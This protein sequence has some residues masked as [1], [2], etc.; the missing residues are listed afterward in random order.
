MQQ[1]QYN[2]MKAL[3]VYSG[4][5]DSTVL[6]HEYKEQIKLAVSFN[7][8]SKHAAQELEKAQ[9]NCEKLNIRHLV[10]DLP[11][12]NKLFRSS[13]LQGQ[14][15]I[16]EGGYNAENMSSTIVPF[17]NGIMLSI[18]AGIAESNG[19]DTLLIANHSGDHFIYPDCRESFIDA[20][21]DAIRQ[22]TEKEVAL[23][24]PYCDLSKRDIALRGHKFG[25][26]FSNT[27]SCYKGCETHCGKCATCM[28]RKE[29]LAG[30]DPTLY[31]NK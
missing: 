3:I 24:S 4:G 10:V 22:G 5:M 20:M 31:E 7:Y 16:P 1:H 25:I 27:Y 30:F 11:F 9:I 21:N 12:I 14:E 8:G 23:L 15:E 28:E 29:A 26:D 17:R 13:L 19:L 18:A 2:N 6:L